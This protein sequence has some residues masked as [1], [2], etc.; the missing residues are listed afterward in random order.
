MRIDLGSATDVGH[1]RDANEDAFLTLALRDGR[2][3]VAVADGM[4]GHAAGEVASSVALVTLGEAIR[5]VSISDDPVERAALLGRAVSAANEAVWA[6][7][8]ESPHLEGMGTTLVCAL[9]DPNG[10][11]VLGNV[12][13]SR[14]YGVASKRAA[15]LTQDHSLVFEMVR[16]GKLTDEQA[17]VHP[18]RNV[19]TRALG[20]QPRVQVDTFPDV[21]LARG[22]MLVLCS[23][24]VSAYF[25][26]ADLPALL[27]DV[28]SAQ[29]A[30]ER[31]VTI[32]LQRGGHD[33]AT[34]VVARLV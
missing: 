29:Q 2:A 18:Y 26:A 8:R 30:A 10:D 31:L 25:E 34:A 3:L 24:G 32:A 11:V 6:A 23:D 14:A 16:E 15:L 1:V 19:V 33:N 20:S 27:D 22:E 13:D 21:V 28:T 7:A 9:V 4:G 17:R 12:G 5:R